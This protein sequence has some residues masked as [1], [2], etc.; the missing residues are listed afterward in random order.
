M[1]AEF[2]SI[3]NLSFWKTITLELLYNVKKPKKPQKTENQGSYK[4]RRKELGLA[5]VFYIFQ[6]G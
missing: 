1:Y 4:A 2:K 6:S 3:K 5:R